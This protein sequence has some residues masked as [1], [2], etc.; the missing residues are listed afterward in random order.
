[1]RYLIALCV[2]GL[3]AYACGGKP[4]PPTPKGEPKK[5]EVVLP[6]GET[7]WGVLTAVGVNFKLEDHPTWTAIGQIRQRKN[8]T[9][10]IFILWTLTAT[11]EACPGVYEFR[12][13]ELHGAWGHGDQVQV[14]A[15]GGIT[16]NTL[17]DVVRR[18]EVV[19][20]M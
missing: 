2:V 6:V 18:V 15:D 12:F 7:N 19:P 13:G 16:G 4:A 1:M 8:G 9:T 10:Y 20:G 3:L 17:A 14:D 11:G 5:E